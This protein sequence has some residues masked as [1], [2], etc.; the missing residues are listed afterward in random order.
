M[1]DPNRAAIE[2]FQIIETPVGRIVLRATG[3]GL[4]HCQVEGARGE[5]S[6][7]R[8]ERWRAAGENVDHAARALERYFAGERK[9][10]DDL[11]LAPAGTPFQRTVWN[12]LRQIPFGQTESYGSLAVRV[13]KPGVARAVGLANG[14]NPIGV[15]VPC[16]RVIGADGSLTG[17]AGGLSMKEWLLRHEGAL[18]GDLF[19]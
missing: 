14:R 13:G 7:G 12:A 11:V 16:H 2:A 6:A 19:A 10:F 15:I 18:A 1:T 8:G 9:Q 17:Y 5:A 4:T 3:E